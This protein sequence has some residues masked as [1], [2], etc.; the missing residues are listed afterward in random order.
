MSKDAAMKIRHPWLIG[1]ASWLGAKAIRAWMRTITHDY[2]PLGPSVVPTQEGLTSRYIYAFWHENMLGLQAQ[3][4]RPDIRILIS[5]HADGE[6]IAEMAQH[7]GFG[8]VRGSTTRNS[9]EAVRQILRLGQQSH[10]AITPDGPR[11][12]RRKVQMG[13]IY[14]AARTGLPI[15]PVAIGFHRPWRMNSW[16]RFALPRPF[17]SLTCVTAEPITVPA[18]ADKDALER[19]RQQAEQALLDLGD[20]A[21]R[22]ANNRSQGSGVR[23]QESGGSEESGESSQGKIAG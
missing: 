11:G 4:A 10:F 20:L 14:L 9:V 21:E 6:L 1:A 18:E 3:Y 5:K 19:Y 7:L 2:R 17:T 22:W 23:S 8:V 13:L 15:V 16:D 12:P